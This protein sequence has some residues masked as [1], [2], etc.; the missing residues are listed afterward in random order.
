MM[1]CT[2]PQKICSQEELKT[3]EVDSRVDTRGAITI[4]YGT[5][6]GTSS[7]LAYQFAREATSHGFD[8]N[9]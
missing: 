5:T 9:G 1:G 3:Q 4:L 2:I 8:A 7:R 6:S